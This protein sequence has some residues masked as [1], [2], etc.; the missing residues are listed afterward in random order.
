M[1]IVHWLGLLAAMK[2]L[3]KS[4]C[5]E[6]V[7][8]TKDRV[9]SVGIAI[10]QK[11]TSNECYEKRSETEPPLCQDSDDPNAAW[12]VFCLIEI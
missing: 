9:N 12:Y 4:I 8:I 5:W 7:Q 6:E 11:T 2:K 3:T 10:Y 1:Q